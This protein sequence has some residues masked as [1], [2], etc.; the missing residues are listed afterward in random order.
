M[1]IPAGHMS[2]TADDMTRFMLAHLNLGTLNSRQIL[3][4]ETASRMREPL[5]DSHPGILPML[6][7]LY[8]SDRNGLEICGHG[9]DV[10]Q[11]HSN[12]SLIPEHNLDLFVSFNSD[13][14]AGARGI[15]VAAFID[16]FLG[17]DHLRQ[18][19]QP[20]ETDLEPYTGENVALR[21]IT[22]HSRSCRRW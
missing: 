9:G 17:G 1:D 5:F 3:S 14:G 20:I 16:H 15:L 21:G 4:T 2:T 11:F 22:R 7:G 13:P 6:H 18:A 19:P 12:L 8:R 10:N